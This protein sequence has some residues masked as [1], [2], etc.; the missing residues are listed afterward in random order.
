MVQRAFPKKG[1]PG[2]LERTFHIGR[3]T[4]GGE[5]DRKARPNSAGNRRRAAAE[6]AAA[7]RPSSAKPKMANEMARGGAGPNLGLRNTAPRVTPAAAPAPVTRR[8][9][10]APMAKKPVKAAAPRNDALAAYTRLGAGS[11]GLK[12]DNRVMQRLAQ[13]ASATA[14][15]EGKKGKKGKA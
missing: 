11:G 10:P 5:Y 15:A 9:A 12:S 13:R 8:A 7:P 2:W 4:P 3:A 1:E 6:Q 14:A